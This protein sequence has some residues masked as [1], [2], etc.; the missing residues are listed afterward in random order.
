MLNA[1]RLCLAS[2]ALAVPLLLNGCI[3]PTA[4]L[5]AKP[6]EVPPQSIQKPASPQ[7]VQLLFAFQNKGAAAT[8]ATDILSPKVQEQVQSSGL[9]SQVAAAPVPGGALLN[10][11][12]DR[13]PP[14][15]AA[16]KGFATGLTF[17]LAGNYVADQYA[18]TVTYVAGPGAASIVKQ[19][20][21]TIY[22]AIGNVSAPPDNI[23]V[24]SNDDAVYTMTRQIVA[25][26][27]RDLSLDPNFQH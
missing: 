27:L 3:A 14:E 21:H 15:D 25:H 13:V 2:L 6:G 7:P 16:S 23:K 5:D 26:A 4:Y 22:T 8:R 20:H 19:A 10:V 1:G 12:I 11:V 18:C 24:D 17:G 9:F